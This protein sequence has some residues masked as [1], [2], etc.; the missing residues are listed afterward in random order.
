MYHIAQLVVNYIFFVFVSPHD[1]YGSGACLDPSRTKV[2]R[3]TT[4]P[5]TN[6]KNSF[7]I[8]R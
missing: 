6:N 8:L 1:D 2:A 7:Y 5:L 3:E 4:K